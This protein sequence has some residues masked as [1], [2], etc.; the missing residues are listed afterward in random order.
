M[1]LGNMGEQG[2]GSTLKVFPNLNVSMTNERDRLL[3]TA[4]RTGAPQEQ[5]RKDMED[6]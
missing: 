4:R 6:V 3:R 2:L 5:T 1:A